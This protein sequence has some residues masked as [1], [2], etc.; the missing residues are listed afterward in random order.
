MNSMGIVVWYESGAVEEISAPELS[1]QDGYVIQDE[2][3]DATDPD[4]GVWWERSCIFDTAEK[5]D[6]DLKILHKRSCVLPPEVMPNVIAVEVRG[7]VILKRVAG[8]KSPTGLVNV[9]Q[10]PLTDSNSVSDDTSGVC[11][12]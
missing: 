9:I 2:F 4:R 1:Y 10:N 5:D 11:L 8:A 12:P 7:V 3:V 6:G